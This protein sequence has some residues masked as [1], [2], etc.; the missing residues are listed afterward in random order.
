MTNNKLIIEQFNLLIKQI[1]FD[2]DIATGKKQM[3]NMFRLKSIKSALSAIELYPIKITSSKQLLNIKNIGKGTIRRI[4]EILETGKLSEINKNI[5]SGSH[6]ELIDE[7][8]KIFG[9]GRKKAYELIKKYNVS[10][11]KDLKQKYKAGI[12]I[13]SDNII[14][15]LKYVGKIKDKIPR[16]EI[17][18]IGVAFHKTL[19]SI[20]SDLFGIICGSY[21]RLNKTSG[22]ID[23][24]ICH[25][26][27][28]TQ[29][30][31]LTSQY[32]FQF[33]EKLKQQK[34]IIESLTSEDVNTK[35]MGLLRWKEGFIRRVDI[36]F[37]PYESYYTAILYFTGPKD[38]NRKMRTI[39]INMDYL[40]NEYGLFDENKKM[41]KVKSEKDI[42]NILGLEYLTPD[43]RN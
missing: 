34:I 15:G 31:I 43:K 29:K 33:I 8:E 16:K 37:I 19:A 36:R 4:D 38:F 28:K 20:N 10:S 41:I 14:K 11:I 17:D 3:I 5:I 7:L 42:F 24:I 27:I 12:V 18:K 2:I 21:R 23:L 40:L 35:Y 39:A 1:L 13:L 9:I 25:P 30:Q 6:L 22:D 32:L 26:K